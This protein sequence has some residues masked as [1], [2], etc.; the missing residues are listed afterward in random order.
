MTVGTVVGEVVSGHVEVVG[1]RSWGGPIFESWGV[2][3]PEAPHSVCQ[4]VPVPLSTY[5]SNG[6]GHQGLHIHPLTFNPRE[7][8]VGRGTLISTML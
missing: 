6:A 5:H 8:P 7:S 3:S 1:C 2:L 4:P